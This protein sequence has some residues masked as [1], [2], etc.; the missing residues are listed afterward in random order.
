M[1]TSEQTCPSVTVHYAQSLDGRI[2]TRTGHAQWIS[3]PESLRLQHEL[4]A[5]HD[6]VLVGVGTA[7]AD[8]PRLTVRLVEGRSPVRIVVDARLRLPLTA[9]LVSGARETPTWIVTRDDAERRRADALREL[10][11]ELIELPAAENGYPDPKE[12]LRAVGKRGVTRLLVEGGATV[13]AMLLRAG[14]TDRIA[15][16]RSGAVMGGD[17]IPAVEAYGVDR[18]ADMAQFERRGVT[19]LGAD[20]LETFWRRH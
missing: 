4:R 11:V 2:A 1:G 13:A 8:D 10:G 5:S 20:L 9:K 17:G 18:L 15:W 7:V 16:F 19:R 3:C 14:L 12:M 6:A